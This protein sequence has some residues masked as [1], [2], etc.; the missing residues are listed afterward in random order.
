[1]LLI[2]IKKWIKQKAGIRSWKWLKYKTKQKLER[3]YY[4]H[5]YSV[6]DIINLMKSM[7]LKKGGTVFVHSSW[8]EFYN[9]TG[10]INDFIDGI[11]DE[12]G[13][14]GTLAMPAY[15]D[16]SL[17]KNPDSVFSIN[18]T[19]TIAGKIAETFRNYPGVKRSANRHSVC[20]LGPMSNF[21]L[22]EH[23]YSITCWDE[24]S[25]Y[26]K[27]AELDALVFSF[28]LGKYFI[29]TMVHCAESILKDEVP[30]F[31]NLSRKKTILR[32]ELQDKTIYNQ[33]YYTHEDDLYVIITDNSRKRMLKYF[34]KSKFDRSKLSNLT[35]NMHRAKYAINE[36]IA[37]GR[38]GIVIYERPIPFKKY[39]V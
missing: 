4:K 16:Y 9:F 7:G 29:G 33:E 35:I 17:S 10:N 11:L 2:K 39:F 28:G 36:M 5:R 13:P 14:D 37:L 18:S 21:L 1:M 3:R 27:L 19:P 34:D 22:E 20:A 30:Y 12:I 31:A 8:S 23:K 25:P 15:P 38:K 6:Q 26:Y 32:I 24:K